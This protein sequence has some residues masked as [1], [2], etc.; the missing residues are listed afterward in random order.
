[1]FYF[2]PYYY[3]MECVLTAIHTLLLKYVYGGNSYYS[4]GN[5]RV[6]ISPAF[7]IFQKIS[8]WVFSLNP[9]QPTHAPIWH[10]PPNKGGRHFPHCGVDNLPTPPNSCH[11]S[12]LHTLLPCKVFAYAHFHR[13]RIPSYQDTKR[14]AEIA[15]K[16]KP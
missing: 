13:R 3:T 11:A 2:I 7:R 4:D 10:A 12:H 6:R 14:G 1:M 5:T 16:I 8:E 15:P 9:R